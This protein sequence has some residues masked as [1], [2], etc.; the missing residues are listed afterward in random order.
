MKRASSHLNQ[1]EFIRDIKA[2]I[3]NAMRRNPDKAATGIYPFPQLMI[4]PDDPLTSSFVPDARSFYLRPV[5]VFVPEFYWPHIFPKGK[6]PCPNCTS[7][8]ERVVVNNW[9]SPRRVVME[10]Q[11][12]DV[13]GFRYGYN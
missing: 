11:C 3:T 10:D 6:P 8:Q 1:F 9:I 7:A 12:A 13:L 2:R 4:Y 5:F